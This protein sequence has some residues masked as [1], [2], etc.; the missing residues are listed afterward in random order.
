MPRIRPLLR[1]STGSGCGCVSASANARAARQR[2]DPALRGA[3]RNFPDRTETRP[4]FD[5]ELDGRLADLWWSA[6]KR[7]PDQIPTDNRSEEHTSELQ[8]QFHLVCRLL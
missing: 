4:R 5:S 1:H 2:I 6:Q 7:A 3:N 8:S